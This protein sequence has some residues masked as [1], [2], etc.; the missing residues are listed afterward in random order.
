[1]DRRR[2]LTAAT[3]AFAAFQP[4]STAR[5]QA[6]AKSVSGRPADAV[7]RDEDF[8]FNI[9]HAF[10]V[11]EAGDYRVVFEQNLRGDFI[12]VPQRANVTLFVNGKQVS[13]N[14]YS[15]T[16]N[17]DFEFVHPVHWEPGVYTVAATVNPVLPL[18]PRLRRGPDLA[19]V[20][21]SLRGFF[22]SRSLRSLSL[23]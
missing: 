11:K 7:A 6:A 9:R 16:S 19:A 15:W 17:R 21:E 3:A 18:Q 12:P 22:E 2:F 1:M 10:T 23:S 4:D 20:C 13:Q 5:A 8:W 14:E